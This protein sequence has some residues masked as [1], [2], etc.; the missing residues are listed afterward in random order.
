MRE[1]STLPAFLGYATGARAIA[2]FSFG[3]R[4]DPS[5]GVSAFLLDSFQIGAHLTRP[6]WD[7][8]GP[9]CSKH[10]MPIRFK[11]KP[12]EVTIWVVLN[13]NIEFL[14]LKAMLRLKRP[15]LQIRPV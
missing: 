5:Q 7:R 4:F 11:C 15:V 8:S 2:S 12:D 1:S 13:L 10:I 14:K 6:T 9:V 3:N